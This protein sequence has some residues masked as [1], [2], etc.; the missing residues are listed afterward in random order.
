[1]YATLNMPTKQIVIVIPDPLAFIHTDCS[2]RTRR[3]D[4][5]RHRTRLPLTQ[6]MQ[7]ICAYTKVV[8]STGGGT[9]NRKANWVRAPCARRSLSHCSH[10]A[11]PTTECACTSHRA[12]VV[13]WAAS[14]AHMQSGIV[15]YLC[16]PGAILAQRVVADGVENRP[17][18]K[19]MEPT[20]R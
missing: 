12:D 1:M 6:V 2:P 11:S 17:L 5:P 10:P 20:E 14:Q 4:S 16:F 8:V 9:V 7:E 18:L 13:L 15:V 3:R 19:G